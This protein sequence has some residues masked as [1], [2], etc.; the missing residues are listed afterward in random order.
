[1]PSTHLV[2]LALGSNLGNRAANIHMAFDA[3][4]SVGEFVDTAF[5]YE[6][7]PAYVVDQPPFLNTVCCIQTQFSPQELLIAC[8]KIE[9]RIGR[10]ETI[11]FGPRVIDIDILFYN[12]LVLETESLT[13]PHP[14]L[15]DRNFV[16]EPLCDLAPELRHPQT[17]ETMQLLWQRLKADPLPRVM[18]VADQLWTWGA[19]TYV[20]GILNVTPDS[21]SGD[22]LM[23]GANWVEQAVV[24][25]ERFALAGAD[26]IDIGGY[27][28][29][30]GHEDLPIEE[31][32]RR[33]VPV[34]E[35][36]RTRVDLPLSIDTFRPAVAAAALEA[37]AH[38]LNDV[39]G[40]RL[41]SEMAELAT[42]ARTP[43]VLMH[44]RTQ[45]LPAYHDRLSTTAGNVYA[46]LTSEIRQ[47]LRQSIE[48]ARQAGL[49]RWLRIID[50]GIGFGKTLEQHM[51]LIQNLAEVKF[52]AYPLLFG[53]S[54]KGFI[55]KILGG[56][57]AEQRM[58]GSLAL[59]VLASERG[60]DIVRV[61]DVEATVHAMR[62]TDAV[63][64]RRI[65]GIA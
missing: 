40:L 63:V 29:R 9:T 62:V 34:I 36:L 25:A 58:A 38:W 8:K 43:L 13:I 51:L 47:E 26:V 14:R 41:F 24:Q 37:G 6:T 35:S 53:A 60:A 15:I 31:E 23:H 54:R 19:R 2:Y 30:P 10:T 11:R 28:T 1:M 44:N 18:P 27:S 45:P 59:N 55:G 49:P 4:Q 3:L 32:I 52:S 22:G 7:P 50:P 42:Q 5:L 48:I 16:L 65:F 46:D 57:P 20:M 39:W 64:G 12:D 56:I 33:V 61:H 17:G 21:F